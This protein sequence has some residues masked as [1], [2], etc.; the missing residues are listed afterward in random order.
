MSSKTQRSVVS[1]KEQDG[2][3][4]L[5]DS[6]SAEREGLRAGTL[7][8]GRDPKTLGGDEVTD[9]RRSHRPSREFRSV[10]R[11]TSKSG[12]QRFKV[13]DA[14]PA[15]LGRRRGG[16]ALLRCGLERK[17][18]HFHRPLRQ[19]QSLAVGVLSSLSGQK[20]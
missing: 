3:C 7:L 9:G 17:E 14:A 4:S 5:L 10:V 18:R 2:M 8:S 13:S 1:T 19:A 6:L 15:G 12:S 11:L 16:K 20:Q